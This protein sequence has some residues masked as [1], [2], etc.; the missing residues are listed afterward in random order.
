MKK[1]TYFLSI[2]IAA[3]FLLSVF[4]FSDVKQIGGPFSGIDS[5]STPLLIKDGMA[6]DSDNINTDTDGAL[7]PRSGYVIFSTEPCNQM[8]TF[9]HSSGRDY[10]IIRNGAYLKATTGNG[11]FD[12]AIGTVSSLVQTAA[13]NLGDKF[14][15]SNSIDGLKYWN[16]SSA[17]V[18]SPDLKFSILASFHGR[19][20]GSGIDGQQDTVYISKLYDGGN[21]TL[22]VNPT[23]EDPARISVQGSVSETLTTLFSSFQDKLIWAKNSSFGAIT[24]S[25]RSNFDI[26]TI[27]NNIG[28][29]YPDSMQD[30]DG[31]L[32]FLA[33]DRNIYEYDGARLKSITD[34]NT[35]IFGEILQ[36]G[37]EQSF[38][39]ITTKSDFDAGTLGYNISSSIT[40]GSITF[41]PVNSISDGFSD[42]AFTT[43]TFPAIGTTPNEIDQFG[44][45]GSGIVMPNSGSPFANM[46]FYN[47]SQSAD[48]GF[49]VVDLNWQGAKGYTYML[50][51]LENSV[52]AG[53][54]NC[55]GRSGY[56]MQ[57]AYGNCNWNG[58]SPFCN[59]AAT[60]TLRAIDSDCNTNNEVVLVSSMV[61]AAKLATT[62]QAFGVSRNQ[63]GTLTM[64]QGMSGRFDGEGVPS[65]AW[66][67]EV[68]LPTTFMVASTVPVSG[69]TNQSMSFGI[70]STY[71]ISPGSTTQQWMP[72]TA[73]DFVKQFGDGVN[74]STYTTETFFLGNNFSRFNSFS[75]SENYEDSRSSFSYVLYIGT[76][77]SIN[78]SSPSTY[79][80]IQYLNNGDVPTINNGNYAKLKVRFYRAVST[81]PIS[82]SEINL[83]WNSGNDTR[84]PSIWGKQRY[85]IGVAISSTSN[86]R[87]MEYDRNLAWQK[88]SISNNAMVSYGGY[89]YFGNLD[90]VFQFESGS[91]DN[92]NPISSMFKTKSHALDKIDVYKEF[93]YLFLTSERSAATLHTNYYVDE[94]TTPIA[95]ANYTMNEKSGIQNFKIPISVTGLQQGKAIAFEWIVSS[96]VPWSIINANLYYIPESEESE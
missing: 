3:T 53:D 88:H 4:L 14:F 37:F 45:V 51:F 82:I 78:V 35:N 54:I 11:I 1:L 16:T 48:T 46:L 96:T 61:T 77:N 56:R 85:K 70:K 55:V 41:T 49:W 32:R 72:N 29:S 25:R 94:N 81:D 34:D 90:G 68:F 26:Q 65:A 69:F 28:T 62:G 76:S 74:F 24:G 20:F 93:S 7:R 30:C 44:Y 22:V 6:E 50:G 91:S 19:L 38:K 15:Y 79:N 18:V 84:V 73:I 52:G 83:T 8:W 92:G 47:N 2:A 10:M 12:V 40:D 67:G 23:E 33:G 86:N 59:D 43:T 60:Y 66:P 31:L 13:T 95:L 89:S 57:I 36:G 9:K 75:V 27:S 64:Y 87:V 5:D 71:E 80:E 42:V 21:F 17:T 63:D 58:M 39:T